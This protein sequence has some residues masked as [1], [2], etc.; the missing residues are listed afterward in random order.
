MAI[1]LNL[2]RQPW[3]QRSFLIEK[4]S[5]NYLKTPQKLSYRLG[6]LRRDGILR[7]KKLFFAGIIYSLQLQS[8]T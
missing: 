2:K 7:N 8:L 4:P 3:W 6:S 1:L 5:N